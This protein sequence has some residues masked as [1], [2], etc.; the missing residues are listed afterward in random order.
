MTEATLNDVVRNDHDAILAAVQARMRG[1]ETMGD[2]AARRALS[3]SDLSRQV[4]GFW[5]QGIASD[6]TLEST[7]T[8]QQNLQWLV[9][10]R[11][12]HDLPFDDAMV[13]RI[14]DDISDE[15]EARLD[16]PAPLAEYRTYRAKVARL[17]ADAF[18]G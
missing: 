13:M 18:P 12:G 17:I 6:L 9:S 15:I 14:F 7:T 11:A 10:F 16:S 5:L 4:L 2:I 8:M 1:D 3:E